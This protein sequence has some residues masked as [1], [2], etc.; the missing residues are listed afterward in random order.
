MRF[1]A[2]EWDDFGRLIRWLL[3]MYESDFKHLLRTILLLLL[4]IYFIARWHQWVPTLCHDH[5][6]VIWWLIL[7]IAWDFLYFEGSSAH[8]HE[9]F[10]GKHFLPPFLVHVDLWEFRLFTDDSRCKSTVL[11]IDSM[12]FLPSLHRHIP[13]PTSWQSLYLNWL[14]IKGAWI[15]DWEIPHLFFKFIPDDHRVGAI[16]IRV[17]QDRS[18]ARRRPF[19]FEYLSAC[20]K[21]ALWRPT[22]DDGWLLHL[23]PIFKIVCQWVLIPGEEFPFLYFTDS[24]LVLVIG[25]EVDLKFRDILSQVR[26]PSHFIIY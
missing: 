15:S 26:G 19:L 8:F 7:I 20:F 9:P 22:H 17:T 25:F 2:S 1:L 13:L 14:M 24:I 11:Q 12:K 16:Q 21:V 4:S 23:S 3:F 18:H 5:W 6:C 10:D